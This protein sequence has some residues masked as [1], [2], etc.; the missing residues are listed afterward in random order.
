MWWYWRE[1]REMDAVRGC[2]GVQLCRGKLRPSLSIELGRWRDVE[3]AHGRHDGGGSIRQQQTPADELE[4]W[5]EGEQ[6]A[7]TRA[8]RGLYG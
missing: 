3:G 2:A 1:W 7:K 8:W 6:K 4:R 5:A